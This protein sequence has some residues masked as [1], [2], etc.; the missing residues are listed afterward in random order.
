[1]KTTLWTCRNGK[2]GAGCTILSFT[3]M[4]A[5]NCPFLVNRVAVWV[6]LSEVN[7]NN[8]VKED[9]DGVATD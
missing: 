5:N 6:S 3:G 1:M 7:M 9:K 2:C 4:I 8:R